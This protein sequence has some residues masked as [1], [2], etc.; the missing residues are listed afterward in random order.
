MIDFATLERPK[1]PNTYLV[2]DVDET[3]ATPDRAAPRYQ[4]DPAHLCATLVGIVTS[5]PRVAEV[6]ADPD[7][8]AYRFTQKTAVLGFVD[9]IDIAV[10][11]AGE[12]GAKVLVYSRSRVGW[13]D[14]GT[15]KKR[16]DGWLARLD[17]RMGAAS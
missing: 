5:E 2:C 4:A 3:A 17:Q 8:R 7:G 14:L 12:G 10:R 11:P 16:V 6:E 1:S 9:D 15:N 13:S